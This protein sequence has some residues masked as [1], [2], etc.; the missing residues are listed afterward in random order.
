[1]LKLLV[2]MISR[3]YS[4]FILKGDY[5]DSSKTEACEEVI[6]GLNEDLP[7]CPF[8]IIKQPLNASSTI[9]S[10]SSNLWRKYKERK[11]Y[12]TTQNIGVNI[13]KKG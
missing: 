9:A 1:M 7:A 10:P 13:L 5:F 6:P 4:F 2:M 3:L 11:K 8:R 12:C